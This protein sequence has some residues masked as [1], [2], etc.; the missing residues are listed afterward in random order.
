M[1]SSNDIANLFRQFG[2]TP[3]QYQEIGQTRL[4]QESRERWP[5]LAAVDPGE[6]PDIPA[7]TP[8]SPFAAPPSPAAPSLAVPASVPVQ[9]SAARAPFLRK[10]RQPDAV[11][12]PPPVAV[13]PPA[14]V[15]PAPV[16][17]PPVVRVAVPVETS[18]ARS[19]APAPTPLQDTFARLACPAHPVAPPADAGMS[20]L[21]RLLRS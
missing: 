6:M 5:L 7:V 14:P 9:P 20:L 3:G 2:G 17:A 4:A 10:E 1:S 18:V 13:A 12:V 21:R 16:A 11:Q 19:A 8:A 15:A